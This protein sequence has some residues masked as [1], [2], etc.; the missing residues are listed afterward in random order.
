[1]FYVESEGLRIAYSVEGR[2]EPIVLVHDWSGEGCYWQELGYVERLQKD[3]TVIVPD[4][5]GHG[6][7]DVSVDCDYG[8]EAFAADLLA[9]LDDL[10]IDSAHFFGYSLGGWPIFELLATSPERVKSAIIGGAHPYAED[11]SQLRVFAP[12]EI[13]AAWRA[14]GAPLTEATLAR[15]AE[16]D[17][18]LLIDMTEDRR[19]ESSRLTALVTPCLMICGTDDWRYEAV[20]RFARQRK[21]VDFLSIDGADHWQAWLETELVVGKL[22]EF[23]RRSES[24][25]A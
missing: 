3:F 14:V 4:L 15:L 9:V 5:R 23:L 12:E 10:D 6:S 8:D 18:Q 21:C 17:H 16:K 20:R 25:A 24:T 1:M 11:L 13:A 19:D 22:L 7:S 2:G